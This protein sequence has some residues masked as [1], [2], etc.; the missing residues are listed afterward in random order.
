MMPGN[1]WY[2]PSLIDKR[3]ASVAGWPIEQ[4]ARWLKDGTSRTGA[5]LGPMAE[6]VFQSTQY[7]NNADLAAM[8]EYL[9]S[10]PTTIAKRSADTNPKRNRR[11][12]QA[13]ASTATAAQPATA[14]M[15]KANPTPFL[16]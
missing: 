16:H 11:R 12:G 2:A 14:T 8:S 10:L 7:A 5:A 4:I 1:D 15:A 6:I 9:K 13:S 3:E